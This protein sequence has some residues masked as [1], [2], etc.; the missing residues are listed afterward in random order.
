MK[1]CIKGD[2][3]SALVEFA[4]LLLVFVPLI[5]L[6]MY[7]QDALRYKLDLQE[8]VVS[9]T[10]DFAYADYESKD[11]AT[12]GPKIID[13][14]NAIFNN[15]WSGNSRVKPT[16]SG[17][18]ADFSWPQD[19]DRLVCNLD[20]SVARPIGEN[21]ELAASFHN[22]TYTKGGL[23]TCHGKLDI[24]NHYIPQF[25]LQEF[26]YK[27]HFEQGTTPL[28][29]TYKFGLLVD[30]W[31][32]HD[33]EDNKPASRKKNEPFYERVEYVWKGAWPSRETFTEFRTKWF[34]FKILIILLQVANS[35]FFEGKPNS[36]SRKV[37]DPTEL[38]LASIHNKSF[39]RVIHGGFGK[40]LLETLAD[41]ITGN[42]NI[43]VDSYNTI[44]YLD[45]HGDLYKQTNENRSRYY[46]GCSK[47]EPNCTE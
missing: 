40:G 24:S 16:P 33:P 4:V 43:E 28:R 1:T 15:L 22:S 13:N 18:W 47:L 14:N 6:P 12:I 25:F 38:K 45:G 31:C 5:L 29:Y 39:G 10:W 41:L 32:I 9:T 21:V 8:S 2:T 35:E 42:L 30:P 34:G 26:G 46:L 44:P 20:D 17:P 36:F 7:F 19:D 11:F 3:G 23:V 37:D 27:E